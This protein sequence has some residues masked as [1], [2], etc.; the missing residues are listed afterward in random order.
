MI[1]QMTARICALVDACLKH[2]TE[3]NLDTL[4]DALRNAPTTWFGNEQAR[5]ERIRAQLRQLT[6]AEK[7]AEPDWQPQ[8]D[9]DWDTISRV[10]LK[11]EHAVDTAQP[12][13]ARNRR[14]WGGVVTL[15]AAAAVALT[16][17]IPE[18]NN[19]VLLLTDAEVRLEPLTRV[20]R[21]PSPAAAAPPIIEV[22]Q[23]RGEQIFEGSFPLSIRLSPGPEGIPLDPGT[24]QVISLRGRGI[25]VTDRLP[26][27][28]D[29]DSLR[30][31]VT[32]KAPPGKH[33][34]EIYIEDIEQRPTT[35]TLTVTV[36]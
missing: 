16:L 36:R 2:F 26:V 24:L 34:F 30:I 31:D 23:P 3:Q 33:G 11:E 4:Q 5:A 9:A 27:L 12:Q 7:L 28:L 10:L 15:T 6:I 8:G 35:T 22:I 13:S 14:W 21:G 17:I 25:D 20:T 18:Q 29:G 19:A 32:A 1:H